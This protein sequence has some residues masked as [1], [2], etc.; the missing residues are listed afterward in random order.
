[1]MHTTRAS[2]RQLPI[3]V[4]VDPSLTVLALATRTAEGIVAAFKRGEL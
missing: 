3:G 4:A 1:M 2:R